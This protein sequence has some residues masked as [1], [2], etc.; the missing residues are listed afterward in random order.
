M[1]TKTI[2]NN[3]RAK[4]EYLIEKTM[5]VGIVLEGT[6]V[7]SVRSGQIN[8]ADSFCRVDENLQVYLMNAH[9]SKYDFGNRNNHEPT[10]PRRLLLHRSEIRPWHVFP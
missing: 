10:R 1:S 4:Y 3:R 6:E 2:A 5:E 9:I 7:K 8:L